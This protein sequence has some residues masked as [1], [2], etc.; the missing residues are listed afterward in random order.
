MP[1]SY[2]ADQSYTAADFTGK[3]PAG[4]YE[5]CTFSG[6]DFSNADLSDTQFQDCVF[7]DSNLSLAKLR[8]TAFRNVEFKACKLLGLHFDDCNPFLFEVQFDH[9]TL[10]LSSFFGVSLKK[11]MFSSCQLEEVDFTEANLQE[12]V[13]DACN[14]SRAVFNRSNLEKADFRSA[15]HYLID[16]ELNRM[17]GA[18]FSVNGVAG[19]LAKYGIQLEV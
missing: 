13:F 15:L 17:K 16:P 14:L 8:Q 9:C 18:R 3:T 12:A 4:E 6:C 1:K 11:T 2:T 10:N 19:L 7:R 5:N